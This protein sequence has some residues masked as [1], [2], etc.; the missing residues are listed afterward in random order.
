MPHTRPHS[1]TVSRSQRVLACA[2]AVLAFALGL[3]A[4]SPSAHAHLHSHGDDH[5]DGVPRVHDDSGC[6]VTLF[7]Q[8]VTTPLDSP[9]VVTPRDFHIASVSP[10]RDSLAP[11]APRHLLQPARGPPCI[12]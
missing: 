2:L 8:G 9:R 6:A 4:V 3:L 12:G 5:H 11:A 7:Q 1:R 10:A